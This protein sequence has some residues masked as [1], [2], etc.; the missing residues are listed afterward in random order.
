MNEREYFDQLLQMVLVSMSPQPKWVLISTFEGKVIATYS[1]SASDEERSMAMT[2][3][4][5][6]LGERITSELGNGVMREAVIQSTEGMFIMKA[7]SDELILSA[8][9]GLVMSLGTVRS[10]LDG[11]ISE[12]FRRKRYS[13]ILR[14]ALKDVSPQ[15]KAAMLASVDGL[16]T[17]SYGFFIPKDAENRPVAMVAAMTSLCERISSELGNGELREAIVY[18]SDG[19]TVLLPVGEENLLC[20]VY[21][22]IPSWDELRPQLQAVIEK[23]M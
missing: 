21:D 8:K 9:F 6:S 1:L 23:L 5:L 4:S 11:A 17:A 2:S 13:D 12:L 19:V 20:T 3:A 22:S 15:P 16:A 18:G 10:Q 14:N 7:I